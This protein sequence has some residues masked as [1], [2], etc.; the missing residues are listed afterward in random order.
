MVRVQGPALAAILLE[1]QATQV[2]LE[3]LMWQCL[4]IFICSG[5]DTSMPRPFPLVMQAR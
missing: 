2:M 3:A 4:V 5:G 1:R